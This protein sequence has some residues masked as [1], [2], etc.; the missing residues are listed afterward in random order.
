MAQSRNN[1]YIINGDNRSI[2]ESNNE[3][4]QCPRSIDSRQFGIQQSTQRQRQFSTIKPIVL[5]IEPIIKQSSDEI[6]VNDLVKRPVSKSKN[7]SDEDDDNDQPLP[8]SSYEAQRSQYYTQKIHNSIFREVGSTFKKST[9]H[10]SG[11]PYD[12]SLGKKCTAAAA[13]VV[14]SINNNDDHDD[15]NDDNIVAVS[16]INDDRDTMTKN[17]NDN[18]KDDSARRQLI[19]DLATN[20]DSFVTRTRD[21]E[22]SCTII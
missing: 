13:A 22:Q 7:T 9:S 4:Q 5:S 11:R 16:M 18:D 14:S 15:D 3:F 17:Q 1:I 8:L 6:F 10:H 20:R 19:L 12:Q 2:L 21:F